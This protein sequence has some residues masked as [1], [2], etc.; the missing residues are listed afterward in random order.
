[1]KTMNGQGKIIREE[2]FP[3][4][5]QNGFDSIGIVFWL[6]FGHY[7]KVQLKSEYEKT[8]RYNSKL[9]RQRTNLPG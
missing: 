1:M 4:L 9:P 6:D 7:F 8:K 5:V 2:F 3:Y